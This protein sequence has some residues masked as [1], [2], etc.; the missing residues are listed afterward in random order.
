MTIATLQTQMRGAFAWLG[1]LTIGFAG[2]F[3]FLISQT[4][5]VS[6]D[7][8]DVK[9]SVA[10]QSSTLQGV[11]ESVDRIADKLDKKK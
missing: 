5:S 11:K 4:N 6:R 8:T 9:T 2:A 3:L 10:A 7:V 1:L